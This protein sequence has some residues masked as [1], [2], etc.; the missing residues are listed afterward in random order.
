MAN[1]ITNKFAYGGNN[2]IIDTIHA[3]IG[4][5]TATTAAWTGAIDLPNLYDGLTIAYYLPRTSA[6]NVTLNL[7]L[8]DGTTTGAIPVYVTATTRMTT[9]FGAGS[10]ILLTYWSSG[11]ISVNGTATTENRWTHADYWNSNT[12]DR[13][14]INTTF[15]AATATTAGYLLCGTDAGYKNLAKSVV[16]D[17]TYPILYEGTAM[18]AAGTRSDGYIQIPLNLT[19][20]NDG[21][22]PGF[23]AYKMVFIKGTLSGTTFTVDS[24]TLFT[25]T[26]PSTADNKQYY[27]LGIAGSATNIFLQPHH[28][29]YEYSKGSF[30]VIDTN[31]TATAP[32]TL[33]GT[34][35]SHDTSGATAGSYGDSGNQTPA[36]GGTFKVPYITVNDTGH[37]TGISEHTVKIP[38]TDNT[39]N[40]VTQTATTTSANYE[41]LFSNTADNTTRT[42][43]AR[44]T[45]T[46]LFNPSTNTLTIN[47]WTIAV[48]SSGNMTILPA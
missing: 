19:T 3:V 7:T 2:Y 17:I 42:E 24:S 9:H 12:Y 25:Q 13:T 27:L 46:L 4:T 20:T 44:K 29:V 8:S 10:T 21:T 40:A 38:A 32:I 31:Y 30:H 6:N 48:D 37:V 36:Y 33:S 41:L 23:T 15:K 18:A 16:F 45:S 14:Y 34:A 35:I 39:N 22:S 43:G 11:S 5:Q 1:N 47:A 28:Q 26:I